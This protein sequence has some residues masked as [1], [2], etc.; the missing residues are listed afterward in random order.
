MNTSPS[1][2]H[3]HRDRNLP[4]HIVPNL[5]T[6][7]LP[8]LHLKTI[9]TILDKKFLKSARIAR[10]CRKTCSSRDMNLNNAAY[11]KGVLLAILSRHKSRLALFSDEECRLMLIRLVRIIRCKAHYNAIAFNQW[12]VQL[13]QVLQI[14]KLAVWNF[15]MW[16][17]G[18]GNYCGY[19]A[20]RLN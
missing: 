12:R 2:L 3:E 4:R 1:N 18:K 15:L 9:N 17:S 7:T 16:I 10:V 20:S 13:V 5:K 6:C 8:P 14:I 11:K 19:Q